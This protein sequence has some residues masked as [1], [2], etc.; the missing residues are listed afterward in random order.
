MTRSEFI[1]NMH[2]VPKAPVTNWLLP[3]PRRHALTPRKS[4]IQTILALFTS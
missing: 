4:F 2:L 1:A 3:A